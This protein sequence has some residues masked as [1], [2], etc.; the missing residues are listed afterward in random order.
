MSAVRYTAVSA[1]EDER[2]EKPLK[3]VICASALFGPYAIYEKPASVLCEI[4]FYIIFVYMVGVACVAVFFRKSIDI[5]IQLSLYIVPIFALIC[6]RRFFNSVAFRELL[7]RSIPSRAMLSSS[8]PDND[9]S[10][11]SDLAEV[12]VGANVRKRKWLRTMAYKSCLYPLFFEAIQWASYAVF[13][14]LT[15][16][17]DFAGNDAVAQELSDI[18]W[19]VLYLVFWTLGLYLVGMFTFQYILV[20]SIIRRDAVSFMGIFGDSP[21]LWIRK[22]PLDQGIGNK[23]ESWICAMIRF[24]AGLIS[25]DAIEDK[26]DVTNFVGCYVYA[27]EIQRKKKVP[28]SNKIPARSYDRGTPSSDVRIDLYASPRSQTPE[29]P[30]ISQEE[31]SRI[32]SYFIADVNEIT[33]FFVPF[34]TALLFFSFTNLVTHLCIFALNSNDTRH[35]WTL[36]RTIIWALMTIRIIIAAARVTNILGKI[37]PHIKYLKATGKLLGEDG[38]WDNFLSLT[39]HFK[40]GEKTFGFPLTMKQVGILIAFLKMTF[41]V[42]L[43]L[44]KV[45]PGMDLL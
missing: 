38:K 39:D 9:F 4:L 24:L 22:S 18:A 5:W 43:S 7:Y 25:M 19:L 41:L 6:G 44:M 8:I 45:K 27:T 12:R 29:T 23:Q 2:F 42:I 33:S 21:F 14:V 13:K 31:A 28:L 17:T 35:Y 11:A 15:N 40:L 20:T 34:T 37:A 32:L 3:P 16:K 30:Q 1:T 26:H 10:S 36:V